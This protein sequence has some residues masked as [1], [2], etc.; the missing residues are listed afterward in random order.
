MKRN[1]AEW[2]GKTVSSAL[3]K[4]RVRGSLQ[5]RRCSDWDLNEGRE[6]I[7]G[8]FSKNRVQQVKEGVSLVRTEG[9]PETK[10]KSD[11]I[12]CQWRNLI[13]WNGEAISKPSDFIQLVLQK[14][15][16]WT[17]SKKIC[18]IIF[19]PHSNSLLLSGSLSCRSC[20]SISL[21]STIKTPRDSLRR[22]HPQASHPHVLWAEWNPQASDDNLPR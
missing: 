14:R 8:E 19:L 12:G 5:L 17:I 6:H 18:Y 16:L 13:T 7:W 22:N 10:E 4:R 2:G 15:I 3:V 20:E 11:G 21:S 1:R 9:K